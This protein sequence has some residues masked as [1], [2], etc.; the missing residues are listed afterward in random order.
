MMFG[1]KNVTICDLGEN[2]EIILPGFKFLNNLFGHRPD[3]LVRGEVCF[4]TQCN[5]SD[6]LVCAKPLLIV[7]G[8]L[9][10]E[11]CPSYTMDYAISFSI[12]HICNGESDIGWTVGGNDNGL[13]LSNDISSHLS[14]HDIYSQCR[15]FGSTAC[16]D[17][18]PA[19]SDESERKR[20]YFPKCEIVKRPRPIDLLFGCFSHPPLLADIRV[21]PKLASIVALGILTWCPVF[22]GGYFLLFG[23][24]DNRLWGFFLLSC[25]VG[26]LGLSFWLFWG[27]GP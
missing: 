10:G 6:Y 4:S 27:N 21:W 22:F 17:R 3:H 26:F 12:P 19:G 14:F 18:S 23:S 1:A 8:W 20:D 13:W 25:G 2:I 7:F 16:G 9:F 5:A 11:G 24:R 15:S